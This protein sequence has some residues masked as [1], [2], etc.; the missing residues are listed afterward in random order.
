MSKV[1][2]VGESDVAW[3]PDGELKFADVVALSVDPLPTGELS[4]S[5]A[6]TPSVVSPLEGVVTGSL[7]V[8][9]NTWRTLFECR[10]FRD[11]GDLKGTSLILALAVGPS[12]P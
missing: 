11:R 5:I 3:S 6:K 7:L 12:L 1:W 4:D 9:L 8:A 10:D 2:A